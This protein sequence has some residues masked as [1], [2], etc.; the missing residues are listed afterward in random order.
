MVDD[1]FRLRLIQVI[2]VDFVGRNV[3]TSGLV[4]GHADRIDVIEELQSAKCF[5][6]LVLT[7][8]VGIGAFCSIVAAFILIGFAEPC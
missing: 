7:K 1:F 2:L 5:T 6:E 4:D 8:S 3:L